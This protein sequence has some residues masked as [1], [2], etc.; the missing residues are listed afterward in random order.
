VKVVIVVLV[1]VV[2]VV[3]VVGVTVVL[4]VVVVVELVV[5]V[6]VVLVFVEGVVEPPLTAV[7]A[8]EI[9]LTYVLTKLPVISLEY[10]Q[11]MIPLFHLK[12]VK[13]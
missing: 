7:L 1:V 6:T 3:L 9:A 11:V 2:V 13:A 10:Y 5:G 12:S 8:K 4:V